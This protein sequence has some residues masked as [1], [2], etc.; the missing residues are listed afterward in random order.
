MHEHR[1][2]DKEPLVASRA[3]AKAP[4]ALTAAG[5]NA[6]LPVRSH[7]RAS[8]FQTHS[9]KSKPVAQH[10]CVFVCVC[11]CAL[12]GLMRAMPKC[13]GVIIRTHKQEPPMKVVMHRSAQWPLST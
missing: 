13:S 6:A 4:Y 2:G 3:I 7:R 8:C 12:D 5:L 9:S 1:Q 10:I 11:V